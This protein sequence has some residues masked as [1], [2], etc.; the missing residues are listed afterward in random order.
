MN[1]ITLSDL[2][3]GA[4]G[5]KRMPTG[6]KRPRQRAAVLPRTMSKTRTVLVPT[7]RLTKALVIWP[8]TLTTTMTNVLD[9]LRTMATALRKNEATRTP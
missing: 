3:S 4:S 8:T 1:E 9:T 5:A 6:R 7:T 2:E